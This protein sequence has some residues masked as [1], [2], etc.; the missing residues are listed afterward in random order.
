MTRP[1]GNYSYGPWHEGP[2]PLAPPIDLSE[3]VRFLGEEVMGG[4]SP[5]A[6][7]R[8]LTRR[9]SGET[10][11]L[12]ELTRRVHEQRERLQR[13]HRLDGTLT[14][15]R[16][17]LRDA[18]ENE[19]RALFPDPS[20]EAR[21]AETE[22]AAL[23]DNT[24][25]AVRELGNYQWRSDEAAGD[26]QRIQELLGQQ[27]LQSHFEGMK[28]A[29]RDTGQADVAR[30]ESML[31]D[32]NALLDAYARGYG[33]IE[34]RFAEFMRRHGDFFPENPRTVPELVDVLAARA[35]AGARM[36]N[37]LGDEQRDELGRLAQQAFGDPGLAERLSALDERLRN[38]RPG[39]DWDSAG[40]FSGE[41]PLGMSDGTDVMDRLGRLDALAEQLSQSYPGAALE[42]IDVDALERELGTEARVDAST[43]TELARELRSRGMLQRSPDG[44]Q[45]LSPRA[46]RNLGETVLREVARGLG[47]ATG[48]RDTTSAGAAGE[49]TGSTRPWRF[50]DTQPWDVSR[51]IRNAVLRGAASGGSGTGFDVSD[52]EVAETEH[53]ERAAVALCVDVSWSMVAEGRWLPMKRTAL[54]LH[55]LVT[56]RFRGDTLRL[57]TFGRYASEVSV[58]EL[59]GLEGTWEQGT[60]LHHALLLAQRHL[61]RNTGMRPIVLLVTDG[62]PTAH[63]A[64][65]GEAHFD[66]PPAPETLAH[67]MAEAGRLTAMDAALTVF[68][69][70]DDPRLAAFLDG[71]AR[72][73]RGRVVA[74]DPDGLGAAVVGDYLSRRA[75]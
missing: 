4:A 6:A 73:T 23:P 61:R 34:Q 9:G 27:L 44:S 40:R 22:L 7:M 19:Q 59:V 55:H 15:V 1:S 56:T 54:A 57:I 42:D 14:E 71:M 64:P 60:N 33:D 70:G 12:D 49:L 74:P 18:V 28:Q 67:T 47:G 24:A 51:T 21:W 5:Q 32:L 2:D 63:V 58:G 41:E 17:L 52:V 65:D 69:L 66:Y 30:I 29:L 50:G 72:R 36:M 10:P 46:L 11:G 20:D 43:L 31:D 26:Y 16:R 3:A 45:Q 37:S 53:R 75:A 62:E 35:A 25:A 48:Q 8:E 13:E 38:L 39:E 68:R